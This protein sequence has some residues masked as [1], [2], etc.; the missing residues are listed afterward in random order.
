METH[1]L[2]TKKKKKE[3][4]FNNINSYTVTSINFTKFNDSAH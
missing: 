4:P 3:H 2:T 1:P